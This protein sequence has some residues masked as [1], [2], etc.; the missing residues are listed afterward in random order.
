MSQ[1]GHKRS[2]CA[3]PALPLAILLDLG[4]VC[5]FPAPNTKRTP[6]V[7]YTCIVINVGGPNLKKNLFWNCPF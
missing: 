7:L 2:T 1:M 5:F 4:S 6:N 3:A